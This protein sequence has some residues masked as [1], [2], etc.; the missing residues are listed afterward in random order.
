MHPE[1][2]LSILSVTLAEPTE[3]LKRVSTQMAMGGASDLAIRGW[4][5]MIKRGQ[6]EV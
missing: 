5:P 6:H 3:E 2:F 4:L 1:D